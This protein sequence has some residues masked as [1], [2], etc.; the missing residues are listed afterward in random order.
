M[1]TSCR[2]SP[3]HRAIGLSLYPMGLNYCDMVALAK[4]AET[5][6]YDSVFTVATSGLE[7][8]VTVG[9]FYLF[10]NPI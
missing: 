10:T 1:A 2:V 7:L 4:L 8:T 3:S 6:G 5:S 9:L